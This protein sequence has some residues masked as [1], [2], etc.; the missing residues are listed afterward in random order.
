M[1]IDSISKTSHLDIILLNSNSSKNFSEYLF[2]STMNDILLETNTLFFPLSSLL[3]S[4]YQDTYST[5]LLVAP[6]LALVL[7]DY[8][9]TY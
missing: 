2:S 4:E 6:E 3:Q 8:T 5:T 9:T 1:V 7:K